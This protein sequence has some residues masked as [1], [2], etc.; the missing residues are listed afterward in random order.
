M[1]QADLQRAAPA[2]QPRSRGDTG[3]GP[4]KARGAPRSQAPGHGAPSG[5]KARLRPQNRQLQPLL[6]ALG[7]AAPN[8]SVSCVL[9]G[10]WAPGSRWMGPGRPS[11]TALQAGALWGCPLAALAVWGLFYERRGFPW[12]APR[13]PARLLTH[14][15]PLWG[16]T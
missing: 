2:G 5:G 8:S 4:L 14:L 13:G 7:Y 6:G 3:T 11:W 12:V 9:W 15:P 16:L 1:G 10:A